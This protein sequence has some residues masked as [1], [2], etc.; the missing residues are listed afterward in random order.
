MTEP[1]PAKKLPPEGST[2]KPPS[3]L[4]MRFGTAIVAAPLILLLIFKA[5]PWGVFALVV[6]A[7]LLGC[8]E[9]FSMTHPD[10]AISRWFGTLLG[11]VV[12][13]GIFFG[14]GDP[15][16]LL[17][18]LL[19]PIVGPMFT[20]FRLGDM[21]S[22]ALR[23]AALGFGPLYIAAPLTLVGVMRRDHP[24]EGP[25]YVLF[26]LMF[27][28]L[29][30][31]GGYFGGRYFGKHKLYE[32]V[33][34]KKTVEGAIG[35]VIGA[36]VGGFIVRALCWPTLPAL[37]LIA[38]AVIAAIAGMAGDLAESLLKRSVGVKDSGNILPGHGGILDRVDATLL[39]A[40]VVYL[41]SVWLA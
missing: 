12:C 33:S 39:T 3:N 24:V 7:A 4:L 11:A 5:P 29:A 28:W 32:A 34:P 31:T 21:K 10:D 19:L 35:G 15:R 23:A 27:S 13:A 16:V 41:Y 18:L 36:L 14:G 8:Y 2:K 30:D 26:V 25:A 37:H 9:L 38:L 6:P 20:L 1:E 17:T 40:T 22:A